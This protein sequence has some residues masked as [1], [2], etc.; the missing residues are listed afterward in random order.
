M[1]ARHA[2]QMGAAVLVEIVHVGDVLEVVG[3][4][5]AVLH[6]VVGQ[7]VVVVIHDLQGDALLGQDLLGLLQDLGVG[8]GGRAHLQGG[9]LLA[10]AGGQQ[11][12]AQRRRQ[13]QG[14]SFLF[15]IRISFSLDDM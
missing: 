12:Q 5:L 15:H 1:Q 10:A 3:I 13:S 4:Q 9:P 7:H 14:Q 8:R 6:V 2:D 11:G